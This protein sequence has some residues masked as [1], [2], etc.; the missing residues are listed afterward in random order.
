MTC[1]RIMV[2]CKH[3]CTARL[4]PPTSMHCANIIPAATNSAIFLS[5]R[6]NCIHRHKWQ[7]GY[8]ASGCLLT[9]DPIPVS[10]LAIGAQEAAQ[11]GNGISEYVLVGQK[12][13]PEV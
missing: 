8:L 1:A 6:R 7:P 13:Y 5:T 10:I 11:A 12:Y 4:L 2:A 3:C 9:P